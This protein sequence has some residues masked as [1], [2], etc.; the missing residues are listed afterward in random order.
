LPLSEALIA[1]SIGVRRAVGSHRT[2]AYSYLHAHP[3]SRCGLP[4]IP[5]GPCKPIIPQSV[6]NANPSLRPAWSF[7]WSVCDCYRGA[8]SDP[9]TLDRPGHCSQPCGHGSAV[10]H[11]SMSHG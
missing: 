10:S 8:V 11:R 9:C 1:Q 6:D 5:M 4:V 7:L 2:Q 3:L